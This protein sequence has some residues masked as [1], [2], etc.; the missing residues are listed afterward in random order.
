M[1]SAQPII[2]LLNA[3]HLSLHVYIIMVKLYN[4]KD[5]PKKDKLNCQQRT[6]QKY[7]CIYEY[8]H[9]STKGKTAGPKGVLIKRLYTTSYN[10]VHM[11]SERGG[12]Q[13]HS[14]V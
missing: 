9:L 5:T 11:F 13:Y 14:R 6:S 4:I 2:A 12:T 7:S 1:T 10:V 8:H 3:I